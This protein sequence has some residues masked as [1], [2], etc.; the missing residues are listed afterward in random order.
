[1]QC[2]VFFLS[3]VLL[4]SARAQHPPAQISVPW[5]PLP[6]DVDTAPSLPIY[7]SSV[8]DRQR[9]WP[10][11][12]DFVSVSTL[13]VPK[14]AL[15]ELDK[16]NQSLA[17]RDWTQARDR[18]IKAISL[19]PSY[20]GAYNNLGVAYAHL[21]DADH[22]RQALEKAVAL[23]DH[24]TLAH[25]NV[26]RMDIKLGRLSEAETE[27]KKVGILAPRD[28]TV[29]GLLS[30]CQLLQNRFDD[31]IT[32]S[33]E[34]HK[35]SSP[36]AFSH[37]VAARAFEHKGQFDHAAGELKVFLQEEPAGPGAD[38]ARKR[39]QIVQSI[40]RQQA[41]ANRSASPRPAQ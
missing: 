7:G 39:L 6:A 26:S 35:L 31:A 4:A 15:K 2:R 12:S 8:M 28:P 34:A 22:E 17:K 5:A 3:F 32:T 33:H 38:A 1:M 19:Y 10:P 21:G 18:L 23:D 37:Y 16:A 20:A 14:S 41:T 11:D 27:L 29:L 36:H 9:S 30:Y 25:L 24:L 40:E 13:G